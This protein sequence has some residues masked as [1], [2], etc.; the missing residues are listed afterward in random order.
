MKVFNRDLTLE[1]HSFQSDQY[2]IFKDVLSDEFRDYLI[3]RFEFFAA[4][5]DCDL[6]RHRMP[7]HKRQ[8]LF[9]FPSDV[10]AQE[11]KKV[12]THITNISAD[13]AV[14]SE[15]HLMIY[16]TQSKPL[17]YPHKD[18]RASGVTVGFPVN[19]PPETAVYLFP[20]LDR[21]ENSNEKASYLNE[22]L[23]DLNSLYDDPAAIQVKQE[24]GDMIIFSGSTLYHSRVHPAKTAVLYCKLNDQGR[25]PLGENIF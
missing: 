12:L 2:A 14:L 8:Y 7:S 25:D 3:S 4:N 23:C 15:R 9:D 6:E 5:K 16:D 10:E 21:S 1:S 13:Q 19:L 22:T 11:F 18:R 20:H 17:P 24:F